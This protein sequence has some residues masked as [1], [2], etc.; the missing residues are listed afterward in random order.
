VGRQLALLE[1]H[2]AALA[3]QRLVAL[4]ILR[5]DRWSYARIARETGLSKARIAQL[6]RAVRLRG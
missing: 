1:A 6:S 4:A 5:A 3:D 2:R